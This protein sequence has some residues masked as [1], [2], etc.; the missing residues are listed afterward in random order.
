MSFRGWHLASKTWTS[1]RSFPRQTAART[2]HPLE[3]QLGLQ[4]AP[5]LQGYGAEGQGALRVSVTLTIL[6]E[7]HA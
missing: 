2:S 3:V 4:E 6:E 7:A 5:S 1:A